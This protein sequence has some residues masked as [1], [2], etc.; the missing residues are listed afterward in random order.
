MKNVFQWYS[1]F[2]QSNTLYMFTYPSD[3]IEHIP[4]CSGLM[5]LYV[6]VNIISMWLKCS[7]V[8]IVLKEIPLSKQ[9]IVVK[10]M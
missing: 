1:V 4:G 10:Q 7:I 5:S 3:E 9:T 2:Q 6:K 8:L